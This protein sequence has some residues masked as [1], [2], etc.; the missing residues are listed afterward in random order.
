M[1]WPRCF[2]VFF[3]CISHCSHAAE[4]IIGVEDIAY[5]PYFDFKAQDPSFS[6]DLLDKFA[7]DNSHKITYLPL[8]VNQFSKWL[9]EEDIDF[10]FPDNPRWQ[11]DRNTHNLEIYFSHEVV[12]LTAGT[13]VLSKNQDKNREFFRNIGTITG[14]HPTLWL[15]QI[16]QG[17]VKIIEDSSPKVLVKQLTH[18]IVDGLNIDLSVANY[19]LRELKLQERL[20][21]NQNT[22]TEAY[23]YQLSTLKY[24]LIIEQF[25]RWLAQN[26]PFINTLKQQYGILAV[27][28][29]L[30]DINN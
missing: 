8:P 20:V 16:E 3:I 9:F 6:K 21:I 29:G 23:S 15:E 22:T 17:K 7:D 25:N 27:E 28:P 24:P 5:Y 19:H 2:T 13:I 4:L 30:A 12:N 11:T 14:F 18:N 26:R 1:A 10:K